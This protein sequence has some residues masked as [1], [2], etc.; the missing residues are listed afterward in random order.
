M[1]L[2]FPCWVST[3]HSR[4]RQESIDA[5]ALADEVGGNASR[6]VPEAGARDA[7]LMSIW[8]SLLIIAAVAGAAVAGMLALR[9]R[10]PE[11]GWFVDTTRASGVFNVL[12]GAWAVVLAFVIFVALDHYSDA[13]EHASTEAF[14][15]GVQH[16]TAQLFPSATADLRSQ[17]ICYAR[18]VVYQEWPA[19]R[20]GK[21]SP[22]V[23]HWTTSLKQTI[24]RVPVDDDREEVG[25]DEWFDA[26]VDRDTARRSRLNEAEGVLPTPMWFILL[27]GATLVVGYPFLFSDRG[28]RR[29]TQA[30][31]VGS[32]T[33]L[34]VALLLVVDFLDH[35]YR[36]ETGGIT[37]GAM[38]RTLSLMENGRGEAAAETAGLPC[39]DSGSPSRS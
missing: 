18:A 13:E 26:S 25:F 20:R 39:D 16:E 28:E 33:S 34:V 32:I 30:A 15:V 7:W 38:E 19:M 35:P 14:K 23:E 17:L 37:P 24:D 2:S 6:L 1:S 21:S 27:L 4:N 8:R 10:S 22:T 36:D 9:R 5:R 11:G 29:V 31:L 12:A 3:Q